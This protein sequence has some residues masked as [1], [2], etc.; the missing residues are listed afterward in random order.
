MVNLSSTI[1]IEAAAAPFG[2]GTIQAMIESA[3]PG[4]P[5]RY[6]LDAIEEILG[7]ET[8]VARYMAKAVTSNDALDLMLAQTAFD[9]LDG[10]YRNE[11]ASA[12]ARRVRD[13]LKARAA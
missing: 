8:D 12:V 11:I 1:L 10:S 9:E 7:P 6:L 5:I 3:T 4:K 2:S 13:L